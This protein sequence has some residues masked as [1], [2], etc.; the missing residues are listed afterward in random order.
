MGPPT[1]VESADLLILESTYGDRRHESA[2][3]ELELD[4]HLGKALGRGG[5]VVVPAFAVGRAQTLLHF[6]ARLKS[7]KAIPDVPVY[8]NSPMAVDATRTCLSVWCR[9][10]SRS[11]A[12]HHHRN[13]RVR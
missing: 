13:L 11:L 1:K 5:V 12:V 7:R 6:V 4:S 8:L 2:D 10:V 9:C 3:P